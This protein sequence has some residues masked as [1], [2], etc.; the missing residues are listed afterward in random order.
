MSKAPGEIELM[1]DADIFF[2]RCRFMIYNE[3]VISNRLQGRE[4]LL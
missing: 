1:V 4:G 3:K 2:G